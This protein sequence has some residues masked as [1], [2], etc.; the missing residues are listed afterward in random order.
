[1]RSLDVRRVH[2]EEQARHLPKRWRAPRIDSRS[3]PGGPRQPDQVAVISV[4]VR[5]VVR[6]EDVAKRR[7]RHVGEY[8]LASDAISAIHHVRVPLITITCAD[9][10]LAFRGRGP[11]PVPRRIE[12][13][14]CRLSRGM[15]GPERRCGRACRPDAGAH[16]DRFVFAFTSTGNEQPGCVPAPET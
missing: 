3:Q 8:E 4:V 2:L 12:P 13:C 6:D 11:P 9:A 16:A 7:Q 1:M 5:V 15:P 10:E 14:L